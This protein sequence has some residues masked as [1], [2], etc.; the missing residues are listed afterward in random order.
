MALAVA[1]VRIQTAHWSDLNQLASAV[2]AGVVVFAAALALLSGR[3][4]LD[5][6]KGIL[7]R[8]ATSK[9]LSPAGT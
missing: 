9:P 1:V 3:R 5:D 8:A 7:P 6:L 4:L 2:G